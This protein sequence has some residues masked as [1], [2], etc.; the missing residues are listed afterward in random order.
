MLY[1]SATEPK[2]AE[3][4]PATGSKQGQIGGKIKAFFPH[5]SRRQKVPHLRPGGTNHPIAGPQRR[6]RPVRLPTEGYVTIYPPVYHGASVPVVAS[7]PG[8]RQEV[9]RPHRIGQL[10]SE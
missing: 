7:D 2:N 8:T 5:H 4:H 3:K 6:L 9:S 10:H 1:S